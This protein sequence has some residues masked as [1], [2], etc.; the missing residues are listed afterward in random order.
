MKI[1]PHGETFLCKIC[2]RTVIMKV[3]GV[4]SVNKIELGTAV[5]S[6]TKV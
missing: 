2:I 1:L 5:I 6:R 4:I 3:E